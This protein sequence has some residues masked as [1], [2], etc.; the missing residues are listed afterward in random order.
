[1]VVL[2]LQLRLSEA[3]GGVGMI[4][5]AVVTAAVVVAAAEVVATI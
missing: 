3:V 2:G 5:V 4:L 1:M